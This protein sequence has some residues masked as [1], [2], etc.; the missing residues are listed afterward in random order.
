[1]SPPQLPSALEE[2]KKRKKKDLFLFKL[3]QS[4]ITVNAVFVKSTRLTIA[5]IS[6]DTFP[7]TLRIAGKDRQLHG[8]FSHSLLSAST[9]RLYAQPRSVSSSIQAELPKRLQSAIIC[10]R[11]E[12]FVH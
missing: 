7:H 3:L 5:G 12:T 2:K 8:T 9:T 11:H 1:M 4:T 10:L 6:T